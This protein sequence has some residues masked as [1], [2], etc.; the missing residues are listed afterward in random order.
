MAPTPTNTQLTPADE[1]LPADLMARAEELAKKT[2]LDPTK[3]DSVANVGAASQQAAAQVS[4]KL[5]AKVDVKDAGQAGQLLAKMTTHLKS[6]DVRHLNPSWQDK[7]SHVPLLGKVFSAVQGA[8]TGYHKTLSEMDELVKQ[9]SGA[10]ETVLSDVVFLDDLYK[11]NQICYQDLSVNIEMLKIKIKELDDTLIPAAKA[12]A[13]GGN[14][15]D[16]QASADL[17]AHRNRVDKK[18]S[19][20]QITRLL[21]IQNAPKIRLIQA[22][23]NSLADQLQS[24][25]INGVPLFKD[26]LAIAIV[27]GRQKEAVEIQTGF[28]DTLNDMIKQGADALHDNSVAIATQAQRGI[29][30]FETLQHQ[31]E[32]LLRTIDDVAKIAADGATNRETV[33]A[34]LVTMEAD[35]KRKLLG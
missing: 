1:H 32:Q 23:D 31:Q 7:M 22:G 6:I 3:A 27:Q 15:T 28:T 17:V 9:I 8:A 34:G 10:R 12:K 26:N 4:E 35:L 13:A 29:V 19:D 16:V 25:V 33:R 21:R 18:I 24:S 30:D 11:Q 20:L 14:P 2:V 5:L